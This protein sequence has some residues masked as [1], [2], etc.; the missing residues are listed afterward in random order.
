MCRVTQGG[1]KKSRGQTFFINWEPFMA[2]GGRAEDLGTLWG[3]HEK[4][5]RERETILRK[6]VRSAISEK[7]SSH[8]E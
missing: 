5:R 1:R 3:K 8:W 4:E 6:W 7:D 2:N